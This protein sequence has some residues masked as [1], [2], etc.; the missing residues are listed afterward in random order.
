MRGEESTPPVRRGEERGEHS[1]C[2]ESRAERSQPPL[3][4]QALEEDER[5][6][7]D[8]DGSLDSG[9]SAGPNF[10]Y[11]LNMPLWCLSKEKVEEL[12]RQR[13]LKVRSPAAP[14]TRPGAGRGEW[15][16]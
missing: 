8:S 16:G 4:P 12:L 15:E 11:I 6:G 14:G 7:N 2:E 5:D 9:S 13:D 1:P 10:N 3:C